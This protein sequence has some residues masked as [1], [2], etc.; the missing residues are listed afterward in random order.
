V[1]GDMLICL[2]ERQTPMP[3]TFS[4]P[5][6]AKLIG[7]HLLTVHRWLKAGKIKPQAIELSDGRKLW[8]WSESDIA[9]AKKLKVPPGRPKKG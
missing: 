9:R 7:V 6:A 2:T 4:T 8:R 1:A 3:K 5:Q